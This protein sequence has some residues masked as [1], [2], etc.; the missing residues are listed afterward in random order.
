MAV[1]SNLMDLLGQQVVWPGSFICRSP[2]ERETEREG[3]WQDDFV[4]CVIVAA[5]FQSP[6]QFPL[7]LLLLDILKVNSSWNLINCLSDTICLRSP[8]FPGWLL[9]V[10]LLIQ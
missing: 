2:R 7:Q 10:A 6:V 8:S 1:H 5:L 3:K 4:G 9:F